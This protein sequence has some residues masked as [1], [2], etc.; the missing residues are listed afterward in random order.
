MGEEMRRVTVSRRCLKLC[1]EMGRMGELE[2][3]LRSLQGHEGVTIADTW[4]VYG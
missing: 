4:L 1:A 2:W 3:G